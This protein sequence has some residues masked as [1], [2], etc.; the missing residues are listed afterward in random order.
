MAEIDDGRHKDLL[1]IGLEAFVPAR[2]AAPSGHRAVDVG[3]ARL[4]AGGWYL[5]R[6]PEG[7]L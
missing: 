6:Y 5:I 1:L 2:V 3:Y 7:A 4:G